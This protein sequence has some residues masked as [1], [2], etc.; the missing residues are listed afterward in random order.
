MQN[1]M[2]CKSYI[3]TITVMGLMNT[4]HYGV[5]CDG[6]PYTVAEILGI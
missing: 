4:Q 2:H 5:L 3:E 1:Y 6:N